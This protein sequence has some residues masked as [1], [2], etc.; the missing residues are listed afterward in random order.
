[1]T[2]TFITANKYHSIKTIKINEKHG[3]SFSKG[4]ASFFDDYCKEYK[5]DINK[6]LH[7]NN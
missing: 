5:I 7:I 1:M 2:I 4:E 6:I 3:I